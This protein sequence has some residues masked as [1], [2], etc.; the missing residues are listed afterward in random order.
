MLEPVIKWSGSKRSQAS[1][2]VKYIDRDYET[3]YEPFCGGCS[4]LWYIL[5][6]YPNRFKH[7]ICSDLNNDLI[8]TF[9]KIKKNY[10]SVGTI[11]SLLWNNLNQ[12]NDIE[13][14]K[15]FFSDV[16]KEFNE[17]RNPNLFFFIMRTTTNGMPRYNTNGDFNNSF[18]VT[19][20]GITPDKMYKILEEWSRML[21][22][23]DVTFIN[24]SY[25]EIKPNN[26]DFVYL[27][28]PYFNTK[29]MY[30][31]TIDYERLWD[32]LRNVEC[33]YLLS[34]DGIAGKE[35]NIVDIPNELYT[36]HVLLD[37]GNSSFRRV[38]GN[39]KNTR[40]FE[41]LY[42]KKN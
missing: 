39:S 5:N 14:K 8:S 15:K 1:E 22:E 37:S 9:N 2:I 3:Y 41:S 19:R 42:V 21:N 35:N 29:G 36:E 26:N 34:F 10:E 7:F 31:G 20:N 13:R 24:S 38:I 12:D 27:D 40:V 4:V 11:Y 18:H 32:Y 28:P 23:Y 17:T 33:D 16:R 30:Y 25:D 6:N